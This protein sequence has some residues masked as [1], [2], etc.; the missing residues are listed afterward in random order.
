MDI[1]EALANEAQPRT[2][3]G[4]CKVQRLLDAIDPATPGFDDLV[5]TV[6]T[7]DPQDP[8]YRTLQQTARVLSR[9]G[10]ATTYLTI[11]NHR[12]GRCRCGD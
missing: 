8:A 5:A 11:G 9:L 12:A 10:L 7:T 3:T 6:E 1:L 4:K 2:S